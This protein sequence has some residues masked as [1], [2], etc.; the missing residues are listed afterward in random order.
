MRLLLVRHGATRNNAE[1]RFTGQSDIPLSALGERQATA[2][3]SRLAKEPLAAVFSS[4]LS[5][6]RVTAEAI[7]ARTEV[8][9]IFDRDLREVSL[10]EWEGRTLADLEASEPDALRLWRADGASHVPPGGETF[11]ALRDRL[12]RAL[13]RT[14]HDYASNTVLWVT[15]GAAIGVLLCHILGIELSRGWQFRRDNASITELDVAA[16]R[17]VI[18]RLNDTAHLAG[19]TEGGEVEQFQVM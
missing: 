17:I 5:R 9:V 18:L 19:V 13:A 4:D 14:H 3:A 2:L 8:P 11:A 7:S 16:G 12:L 15:H 6:A 10:G 1:A